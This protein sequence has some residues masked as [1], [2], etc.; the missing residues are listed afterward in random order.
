MVSVGQID[1]KSRKL[2][3]IETYM[4]GLEVWALSQ[5]Q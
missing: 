1:H 4:L 2:G 5:I 3:Y